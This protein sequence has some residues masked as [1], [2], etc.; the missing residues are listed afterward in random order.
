MNTSK[1]LAILSIFLAVALL[2]AA[3]NANKNSDDKSPEMV[4]TDAAQTA[5]AQLTAMAEEKNPAATATREPG[6]SSTATNETGSPTETEQPNDENPAITP[7]T[8]QEPTKS[9][10]CTLLAEFV[11][12]ITVPDDTIL[13]PGEAFTKTWQIMNSGTCTWNG[14]YTIFFLSGSNLSAPEGT[15]LTRGIEVPPGTMINV[16][17]NLVAPTEEGEYRA[18]FKFKDPSGTIFGTGANGAGSIYVKVVVARPT[19]TPTNTPKPTQ[20]PS[21]TL[22]PS[23]TDENG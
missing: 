6:L 21:P 3:C 9:G 15:L 18:D 14:D 22:E 20:E 1:Y 11:G 8:G 7:T 17:I 2:F 12:D 19:A 10:S 23:P 16:S 13:S 4:Y 5:A